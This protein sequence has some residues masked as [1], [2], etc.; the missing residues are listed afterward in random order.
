MP[1]FTS[2]G[3]SLLL[4]KK[5]HLGLSTT[6]MISRSCDWPAEM[7]IVIAHEN[8]DENVARD[9]LIAG[10]KRP[11]GRTNSGSRQDIQN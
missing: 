6:D 7:I 5:R 11:P 4:G 3:P 10:K 9:V 1:T 8:P 2:E